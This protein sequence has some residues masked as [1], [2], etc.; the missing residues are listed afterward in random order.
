MGPILMPND[1]IGV[2]IIYCTILYICNRLL[3]YVLHVHAMCAPGLLLCMD[4][5]PAFSFA[6]DVSL[7]P[8]EFINLSLPPAVRGKIDNMLLLMLVPDKLKGRALKNYFDFAAK[9][10]MN[11]LFSNGIDG[12]KVKVFS[13]S[14]DT[15]GRAELLGNIILCVF[16]G[17]LCL[18][19]VCSLYPA[20][21]LQAVQSYQSCC[22]CTHTWSRGPRTKC[23]YDGYRCFV[24]MGSRSRGRRVQY[25]GHVYEYRDEETRPP[26]RLRT[27]EL[28][29]ASAIYARRRRQPV[30]GHKT[31]PLLSNWPGFS[32]YRMNTPDLMHDSKLLLEMLLKLLVGH[33]SMA[34]GYSAWSKDDTHRRDSQRYGV[35]RDV[36]TDRGGS[37]PW[38]L[39]KEDREEL[40]AR[41]L[42]VMWP[43]HIDRIAYRGFSFWKKPNRLW[44]IKR[45]ITTLYY[46]LSTALRD[47]VA[48]L[49]T[50]I[51]TFVWA[52]RR[53]DG[54]VHSHETAVHHLGITPGSR[55]V[56]KNIV[57]RANA[58]LIRSL[59]LFEGC[60][61]TTHLNPALH[62]FVH[63]AQYTKSHGSLRLFWMMAF[64]R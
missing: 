17:T 63:Y 28:V 16:V 14:M 7:K 43:H 8:L 26:P 54:Q 3:V 62:H 32:W 57:R 1:R 20:A 59:C 64:E 34:G 11:D 38:R 29:R 41:M 45:K 40:D 22:V 52:M 2:F 33:V 58:D 10:E 24:Q 56:P 46:V 23:M 12:V 36:W 6:K 21:G 13:T 15:P 19:F 60:I 35:F 4:G 61:P 49:R 51:N 30:L 55:T 44:K 31:F 9:F 37:F 27:D 42:R 50:A 47:K 5:I 25:A 48:P 18:I 39:A 53:L